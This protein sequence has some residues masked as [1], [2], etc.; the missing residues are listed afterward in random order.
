MKIW[1]N[2]PDIDYEDNWVKFK[3]K[4]I[5]NNLYDIKD[6]NDISEKLIKPTLKIFRTK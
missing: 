2:L 1:N 4:I 3:G 5:S 6:S